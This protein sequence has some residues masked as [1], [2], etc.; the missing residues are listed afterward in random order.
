M[1][2]RHSKGEK[3]TNL[4]YLFLYHISS[5]NSHVDILRTKIQV[6]NEKHA[7]LMISKYTDRKF[8]DDIN[9]ISKFVL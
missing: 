3:L 4:Q 7:L 6:F 9:N 8:G 5:S 2:F 1:I